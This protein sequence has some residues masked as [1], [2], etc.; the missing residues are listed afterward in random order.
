MS[1]S[2]KPIVCALAFGLFGSVSSYAHVDQSM[3]QWINSV[4]DWA[5]FSEYYSGSMQTTS[6]VKEMQLLRVTTDALKGHLDVKL[7]M[8]E[9]N[10][11]LGASYV[12][13]EG[14]RV[15]FSPDDLPKGVVIF[16]KSNR[17]VAK[18][19]SHDFTPDKNAHMTLLYLTNGLT[20]SMAEYPMEIVRT[21]DSWQLERNDERGRRSFTT[22]FLKGRFFFGKVIGIEGVEVK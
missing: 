4:L 3:S 10:E 6:N 18:M 19:V 14:E 20:G 21:R 1:L 8:N 9:N 13:F 15:D 17:D 7:L 12:T 11:I 16:R 2:F 22:M 5:N